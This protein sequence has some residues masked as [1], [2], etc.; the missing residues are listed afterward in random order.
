MTLNKKHWKILEILGSHNCEMYVSNIIVK[1]NK[2]TY[3]WI[4]LQLAQL[5]DAGFVDSTK[6]GARYAYRLTGL[7]SQLIKNSEVTQ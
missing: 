3:D 4:Y 2:L 5:E 6:Y 1:V 7:G